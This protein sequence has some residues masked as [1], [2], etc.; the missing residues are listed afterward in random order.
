MISTIIKSTIANT[1]TSNNPNRFFINAAN[2]QITTN[3][4]NIYNIYISS[5]VW[6]HIFYLKTYVKNRLNIIEFG[7][8]N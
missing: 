1:G 2:K 6:N 7:I 5:L 3:K 4:R 8:K